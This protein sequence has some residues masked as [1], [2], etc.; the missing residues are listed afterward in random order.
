MPYKHFTPD[1]RNELSALLRAKVKKKDIARQL[2]KD[3]TSVW[4]ELN[5]NSSGE[6]KNKYYARKAKR[7]TRERR[8]KA[9]A[10][11][12]KIENDKML[13]RYIVK[14]LKK[15]WSPDQIAGKWNRRHK[16]K[17]IGKDTIYKF[18]Y[19][20]R[21]DLVKY[22]RCQKGRYRRRYGTRLREKQ[23]EALKKRRI[24]V[25]PEIV[26]LKQRIGDWE[27]DT[28]IGKDKKPA[29]LTYVERKSGLILADKLERA[30]ADLT[31][32]KTIERFK[33]MPKDKRHTITY[34]NAST[35]SEHDTI[36]KQIG[37]EVYFANPY[38]SWERGCNE[39]ANGLLRQFFPKKTVFATITQ[40]DIQKAVRLLNNRPRKRL[41]YSTPYEVFNQKEKCCTLE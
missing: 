8:I 39:N 11:F 32:Q 35:F 13:R 4:R 3:R 16:R 15:Y 27:G 17:R 18:V 10:R 31:R 40:K 30:T 14:K 34:D 12:R 25:R 26:E 29:I 23:R 9:N 19:E 38:H 41:S 37:L 7:Q 33:R 22:L 24:D 6:D 1:Q 36:E 5:R 21:K 28:I 2:K 20:K